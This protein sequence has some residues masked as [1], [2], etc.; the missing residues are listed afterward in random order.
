MNLFLKDVQGASPYQRRWLD[1]LIEAVR[2]WQEYIRNSFDSRNNRFDPGDPQLVT[3]MLTLLACWLGLALL[4]A[5]LTG[6]S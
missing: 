2:R 4:A 3:L 6:Q 5:L 1:D